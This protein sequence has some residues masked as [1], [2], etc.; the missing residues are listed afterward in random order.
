MMKKAVFILL[1]PLLTALLLSQDTRASQSTTLH[2]IRLGH[3]TG[4]TRLVFD[5]EGARPLRIG[6]ATEEGVRVVYEQLNLAVEPD[7]L[8]RKYSGAAAKVSHHREPNASVVTIAFT[9]PNTEVRTFFMPAKP[10]K[11]GGYRLILDFYPRGSP[12]GSAG[13]KVP[14]E[15]AEIRKP[16]PKPETV[17]TEPLEK[18]VAKEEIPETE[19]V[20]PPEGPVEEIS[21][22]EAPLSRL[23]GEASIIFRA[24]DGEDDSSKFEE[25]TDISGPITGA[26]KV[27]Y[28][29]KDRY[30]L[31]LDAE[32]L[33]EDDQHLNFTGNRYGMFKL[34]IDYDRIPHRYAF[35]AKTL[36]SG[37]GSGNLT[38]DDA[39]QTRLQNGTST[40]DAEFNNA[41]SGDPEVIRDKVK[42]Y[43]DLTALDPLSLRVEFG[44]E[45]RDGT[46]PSFG[47]FGTASTT[48]EI[49]E[50]LDHETTEMKVIAEYAKRPFF[51]N[52]TYYFSNFKNNVDTLTWDNP[53][54]AVDALLGPSKGLMD[55]APDNQFHNVSI[56]GSYMDLPLKTRIS[57]TAGWGLMKQDDDLVPFTTNTAIS[58]PNLPKQ[59]VDA[60]V[61]TSLYNVLLTARPLSFMRVKGKFRYFEYDNHTEQIRFPGFVSAD[62]FFSATPIVNLPAS[63][64]KTKGGLD[65]SFDVYRKTRL[66]L[67]YTTDQTRRTN[68]EVSRQK[69]DI[70]SGSVDT[71]PYPWLD[72]RAS[73]ERT[74]RDISDYDFD[75]YLEGG[76]DLQQLP[77]LRKYTQADMGRN[78]VQFLTTVYPS[79]SLAVSGSFIY[80]NDDF[81]ESP[82]GLL[83]DKHFIFSF[84]ADYSITEKLNLSAFY[85]YEKYETRQKG[86]G[87]FDGGPDRDWI[88]EGEDMVNTVGGRINFAV[89]PEK[90][91]FDLSYSYSDV[92]GDIDFFI[93]VGSVS[94]FTTVDETRLHIL[95]VISKYWVRKDF[96]VTLGYLWENFDFED[97]NTA[98]LTYT[99]QGAVLAGTLP[100]DYNVNLVYIKLSYRF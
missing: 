72:L 17:P 12:T 97:F 15:K 50:P 69:D 94:D 46:R 51:L 96:F 1:A 90:L 76:K 78:R 2:N 93:P 64:R 88:A 49:F 47:S 26:F 42:A 99:P 86:R 10:P 56:S 38:L 98:G 66:N 6:P 85:S 65:L 74:E 57:A 62:D 87:P 39:M 60:K 71:S 23:S 32:D 33:A 89:I 11:K 30:S 18:Q 58:A 53:F 22:A 68:R 70:F 44:K 8:F 92:D 14:F 91:D 24:V 41:V 75:P 21:T 35:D 79:E 95:D 5:S 43:M 28:E 27:V 73:Y 40:I 48:V 9:Y 20:S 45:Y 63:Y 84:D 81:K 67:G 16:A 19:E 80:G 61:E 55:L 13:A 34:G 4:F 36:Y 52:A 7:R 100:E 54:R 37:V 25:Y 31:T 29:K 82:Y 77:L 3:H 59:S 83:E